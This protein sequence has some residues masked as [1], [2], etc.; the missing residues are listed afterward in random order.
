MAGG[1]SSALGSEAVKAYGLNARRRR[2]TWYR[3]GETKGDY[4]VLVAMGFRG[5]T[6]SFTHDGEHPLI[7]RQGALC[8]A[9]NRASG[10][11]WATEHA[12][13]VDAGEIVKIDYLTYTLIAMSLN[14]YAQSAA[15]PGLNIE[16]IGN[17]SSPLPR[18]S[19]QHAIAV[20]LDRET[21]R[22][23]ALVAKKERLIELLQEKR[24]ALITQAVNRGLDPNAPM[25][26]SGV[27]WLGRFRPIGK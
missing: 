1:D 24:T 2:D 13:V 17:V 5:Y 9:I 14:R 6:S 8:G 15:Q 16:V 4:P 25:K 26:D 11:F 20:F 3:I 23:D 27:E 10:R 19:E 12:V 18:I 21:A 22:I 7:G